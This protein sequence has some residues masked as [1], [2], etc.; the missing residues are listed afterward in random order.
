MF[1]FTV[2]ENGA[3]VAPNFP[4]D[5]PWGQKFEGYAER[6]SQRVRMCGDGIV[7]HE[8]WDRSVW[9][10]TFRSEAEYQAFLKEAV[11]MAGEGKWRDAYP[12]ERIVIVIESDME[13]RRLATA[14]IVKEAAAI[15]EPAAFQ[16]S[17]SL[18]DW[19]YINDFPR[20]FR[21]NF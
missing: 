2:F 13:S 14:A 11:I 8:H 12:H 4:R 5:F 1:E 7:P 20:E 9:M 17:A 19:G 10:V 3:I 15:V 18:E 6:T 16:P 21:N